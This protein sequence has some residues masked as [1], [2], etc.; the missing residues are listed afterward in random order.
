MADRPTLSTPRLTLRPFRPD[1]APDVRRLAGDPAVAAKTL[2][3]PHPYDE[4]VA[5]TWIAGHQEAYDAGRL[6]SLAVTR[7]EDGAL[8]GAVSL[9]LT[10]EHVRGELG[11]WIGRAH[12]GRGYATEAAEALMRF[13]FEMLRLVRVTAHIMSSNPASG[14]VLLKIGMAREGR[15]PR[16]VRKN[17]VFEDVELFGRLRDA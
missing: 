2:N 12:W 9:E 8:L 3:I 15:L 14:R 13:G 5:E 11:Y 17:G 4:G 7:T 16:H 1:D 10:P 6:V